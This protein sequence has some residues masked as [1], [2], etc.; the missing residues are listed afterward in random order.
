MAEWQGPPT[1]TIVHKSNVLSVTDGLFRTSV[2]AVAADFP[3]VVVEEQLV[4]SLVYRCGLFC[5][6]YEITRTDGRREI[7]CS[8]S[9]RSSV[10]SAA[11]TCTVTSS[12]TFHSSFSRRVWSLTATLFDSDGGAALVGSLGLVPSVNVGDDFIM[13]PSN[14]GSVSLSIPG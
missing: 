13:G 14:R 4:D 11:P 9:L 6:V 10:S 8:E 1:V 5:P 12:R 3:D 7:D 2:R